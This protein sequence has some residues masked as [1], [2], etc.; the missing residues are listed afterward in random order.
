[1]S[2]NNQKPFAD[3]RNFI[4][5]FTDFLGNTEGE[6][7][8]DIKV[9]LKKQ[10]IDVEYII[11]N[12]KKL[13]N[14][15]IDERKRQWMIDAKKIRN[16]MREQIESFKEDIPED[17]STIKEKIKQLMTHS[18]YSDQAL[19][20]FRNYNEMTDTELKQLYKDFLKLLSLQKNNFS[21]NE[22]P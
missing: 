22:K 17:I 7:K 9:E 1:M 13:I 2:S 12:V 19:A 5:L 8:E 16:K 3:D 11:N 14:T 20:F 21:G 6:S 15:K 18:E 4:D 10:G